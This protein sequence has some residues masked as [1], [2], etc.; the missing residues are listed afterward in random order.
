VR[1]VRLTAAA[2]HL[3]Y[4]LHVIGDFLQFLNIYVTQVSI[5]K[6]MK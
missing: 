1:A 4:L 6:T 3:R 5:H 2:N